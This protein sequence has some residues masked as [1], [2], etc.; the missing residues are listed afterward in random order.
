MA[1]DWKGE[2][3]DQE[4]DAGWWDGLWKLLRAYNPPSWF[5]GQPQK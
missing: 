4:D 5:F 3:F 2:R 1:S